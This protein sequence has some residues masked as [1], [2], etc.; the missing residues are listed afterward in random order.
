ML[1]LSYLWTRGIYMQCAPERGLL[2]IQALIKKRP[3]GCRTPLMNAG[4]GSPTTS[5]QSA[6]TS[7]RTAD[8]PPYISNCPT[9]SSGRAMELIRK[10][11]S[12]VVRRIADISA[13]GR[14][15]KEGERCGLINV[16]AVNVEA[17]NAS[18]G[19]FSTLFFFCCTHEQPMNEESCAALLM[20]ILEVAPS[21]RPRHTRMLR[22]MLEMNRPPLEMVIL[23]LQ[24]IA[25]R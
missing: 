3:R 6:E 4:D 19:Q 16:G 12:T 21:T 11:R 5:H 25:A 23:G 15:H 1:T 2:I 9:Q 24:K 8:A 17:E 22:S 18:S 20:G 14:P 7:H 10:R 13:L